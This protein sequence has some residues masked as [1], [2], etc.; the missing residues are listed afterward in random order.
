MSKPP[1]PIHP[2]LEK[3]IMLVS[4][5]KGKDSLNSVFTWG[6]KLIGSPYSS[7]LKRS[8]YHISE[9]PKVPGMSDVKYSLFSS[10]LK[11]GWAQE[12]LSLLNGSSVILDHSLPSSLSAL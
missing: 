9:L 3:Y 8:T 11:A 12:K 10:R 4:E 1:S 5:I 2:S 6:P 7:S